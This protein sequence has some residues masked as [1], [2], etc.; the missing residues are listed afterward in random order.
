M[1]TV[2]TVVIIIGLF[3]AVLCNVLLPIMA[4]LQ[5][6]STLIFWL[7][8]GQFAGYLGL[9]M[10]FISITRDQGGNDSLAD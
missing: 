5:P 1:H 2:F 6:P 4:L 8:I 7:G 3:A 10:F 9:T